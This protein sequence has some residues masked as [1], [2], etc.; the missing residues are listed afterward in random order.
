MRQTWDVTEIMQSSANKDTTWVFNKSAGAPWQNGCSEALIRSVK[1]ALASAIGD[2]NLTFEELQAVLLQTPNILIARPIGMKR[3]ID[4][5]MG[6]YLC[7]NDMLLGRT[8]N[9]LPRGKMIM[10]QIGSK[11]RLMF[12]DWIVNSF[13]KK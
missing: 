12:M 1:R 3:G 5:E 2:S 7:P 9:K 8:N 4:V 11:C 13:W 10:E 6:S